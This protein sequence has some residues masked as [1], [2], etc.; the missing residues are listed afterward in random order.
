MI[1]NSQHALLTFAIATALVACGFGADA[2]ANAGKIVVV[3]PNADAL[4]ALEKRA[5]EAY[6]KGNGEFFESLL[7]DKFVT[8]D[9]HGARIDKTEAVKAISGNKCDFKKGWTLTQ[10]QLLKI[11]DD[12]YVLSYVSNMQGSCTAGGKTEEMP[13]PVRAATVWIGKGKRW[14]VAFHGENLIVDPAVQPAAGKKTTLGKDDGSGA[15]ETSAEPTADA[16][17]RDLMAAENALW[18]AWKNKDVKRLENL[19]APQIAFVD[20]FGTFLANK[21]D[22]IKDWTGPLCNVKSINL[23]DGVGT[24]VSRTVAILTLKAT[25]DG[26]CGGKNFSGLKVAG[27]SVY[28]RDGDAWK[29]VFGFNSPM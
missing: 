4:L 15:A 2:K 18:D 14:Q 3:A 7:S 6:I 28:V 10:P 13:S 24:T 22:T 17:T 27:N 23:A 29:W 8:R 20:Y 5:N 1:P 16:I 21:A 25:I 12:A 9:A 26:T 11:D 19:T